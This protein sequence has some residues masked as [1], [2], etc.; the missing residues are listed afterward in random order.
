[1]VCSGLTITLGSDDAPILASVFRPDSSTLVLSTSKFVVEQSIN[2]RPKLDTSTARPSLIEVPV[3]EPVAFTGYY[4]AEVVA[5]R[6]EPLLV[7]VSLS[8][9]LDLARVETAAQ[10]KLGDR[11]D[12]F[13]IAS[14]QSA[15]PLRRGVSLT[16][17]PSLP[18]FQFIPRYRNVLWEED[19]QGHAFRMRATSPHRGR[20]LNGSVEIY[21]EGLL[22]R[23]EIPL[24]VAVQ[25]EVSVRVKDPSQFTSVPAGIYRDC[26][27]S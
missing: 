24:S 4:P 6:W 14:V 10:R 1:M 26:F 27:P 12:D 13:Q 25:E 16:I 19:V 21:E 23:G 9:P 5:G 20:T 18:G 8:T 15:V 22:L 17:V 3:K 7:F 2:S 11:R